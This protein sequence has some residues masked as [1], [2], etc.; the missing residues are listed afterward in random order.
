MSGAHEPGGN[1][2]LQVS[3]ALVALKK[4]LWGR[5]PMAA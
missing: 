1:M 5:G 2:R 3:N 4:Q